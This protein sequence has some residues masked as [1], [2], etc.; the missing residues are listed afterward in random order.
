MYIHKNLKRLEDTLLRYYPI[1]DSKSPQWWCIELDGRI[2]GTTALFKEND[3]WHMGRIAISNELRG[4]HVGTELLKFALKD[5][6]SQDV[7]EVYFD[8]RDATVHILKKFGAQVIGK[9]IVFYN[10]NVTPIL[11]KKKDFL[12]CTSN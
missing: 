6:F 2:V 4:Q 9:P 5:I 3:D 1:S 11:L 10:G 12:H 7:E 8:A